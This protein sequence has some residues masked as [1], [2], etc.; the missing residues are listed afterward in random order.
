MALP[1]PKPLKVYPEGQAGKPSPG[2]RFDSQH[3]YE[4]NGE[5]SD[6]TG[7][8]TRCMA[9][10]DLEPVRWL[11]PGYVP[12]GKLVL[13]AGDGGHGKSSLMLSLAASLSTG[14]PAFG[15][16]YEE[17]PPKGETLLICGEDDPGDTIVPRLIAA[18]ADLSK[19]HIVDGRPT[20]SGGCAPFTLGQLNAMDEELQ[21]RK[22][23]GQDVR[24][25]IIDPVSA[26]L[27]G[28]DDNND[29]EL[30]ALLDPY[31]QLVAH[32][33][34]T[35]GLVRHFNKREGARAIHKIGGSIAYTNV[36]RANFILVPCRKQPERRLFLSPKFNLGPKPNGLAFRMV[37]PSQAE[38]RKLASHF[39][40]LNN[41]D[42]SKMIAQLFRIEWLGNVD[43]DADSALAEDGAISRPQQARA[44]LMRFLA[45]FAFPVE[46][47]FEEGE[48]E[49]FTQSTLREGKGVAPE[50][51]I[52]RK[53]NCSFWGIGDPK[54][55]KYRPKKNAKNERS[56]IAKRRSGT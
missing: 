26:F 35:A 40:K 41:Q 27:G 8:I 44:W 20:K 17:P 32:H 22:A 56:G 15:L 28:V 37:Q 3:D 10:I 34:A 47:I 25:I 14:S 23:A 4:N 24:L 2:L 18:G 30:R 7:L 42:R 11:V 5:Q 19:I 55:W 33:E 12:V 51:Q 13:I 52:K 21:R 6:P 36:C 54:S 1:Q 50:I 49:G 48:K 39:K 16:T 38:A 46:E 43:I 29:A 9:D 45:D 31:A 53:S